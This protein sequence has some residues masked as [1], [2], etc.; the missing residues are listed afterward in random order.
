MA[1]ARVNRAVVAALA[2]AQFSIPVSGAAHSTSAKDPR[3]ARPE[4]PTVATHAYAVATGILEIEAGIQSES[5]LGVPGLLKLGLGHGL[6]L[7]IAPG[8]VS[9]TSDAAPPSG[10]TDTTFGVKWHLADHAPVLGAFALQPSVTVPT[11]S[12]GG[13][14]A[15]FN[16]LLISSYDIRGVSLD[17]N[18]GATLRKET[19]ATP[20]TATV[21]AVA[22]GVPVAGRLSWTAEVFGYPGTAGQAG[23][24][25]VVAFLTGPLFEVSKR[26][27][28]D[29]GVTLDLEGF[30]KTAV[31]AGL[32]WNAARLWTPRVR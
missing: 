5:Q 23:S 20:W 29:T 8:F 26:L 25:P 1:N 32:T 3:A 7:D 6:Q 21:W 12:G 15:G 18:V 10:F 13:E 11:G 4:R 17:V 30:G 16:L 14:S 28:L 27:V 31:F 9:Q 2:V 24:P 22:A 19:S